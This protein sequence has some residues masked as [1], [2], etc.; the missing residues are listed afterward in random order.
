MNQLAKANFSLRVWIILIN[1][2]CFLKGLGGFATMLA[3]IQV[4]L[5]VMLQMKLICLQEIGN[6][7]HIS[8]VVD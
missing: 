8:L 3:S 5:M 4:T 2:E 1:T 6:W 7:Q